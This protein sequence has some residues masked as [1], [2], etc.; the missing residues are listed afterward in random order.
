MS[1][2]DQ[3]RPIGKPGQRS[4]K[5]ER[6]RKRDQQQS[7]KPDQPQ[8]AR[9][10]IGATITPTDTAAICAGAL[11]ETAQIGATIPATDS[12]PSAAAA[13]KETA[14]IGTA[15]TAPIS[16]QTIANAYGDCIGKSLEETMSFVEKLTSVRSLDKAV[17]V[18]AEFAKH[19]YDAFVADS[20][21]IFELYSELARQIFKPLE[22]FAVTAS[23]AKP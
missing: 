6:S 9:E 11:E 19:A 23:P 15:E 2:T 18:Q 20:R 17:E 22:S 4:R 12:V 1:N 7:H 13:S 21:R 3:N 5:K 16:L 8:D 14:R 10:Q